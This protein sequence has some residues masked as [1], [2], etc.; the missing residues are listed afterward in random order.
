[1]IFL[2]MLSPP[3]HK[4]FI[5]L[6][7]NYIETGSPFDTGIPSSGEYR[8]TTPNTRKRKIR[9]R[10]IYHKPDLAKGNTLNR[11]KGLFQEQA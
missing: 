4:D 3:P 7:R 10:K 8:K 11:D 5:F 6:S 2:F 1:M 9:V